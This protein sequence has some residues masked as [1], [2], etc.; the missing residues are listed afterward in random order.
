MSAISLKRISLGGLAV[1]L[2]VSFPA[3][4]ELTLGPPN[5]ENQVDTL[6]LHAIRGTDIQEPSGVDV[7]QS[8]RVLVDR[9]WFDF[10][11]DVEEGGVARV[12][13]AGA[14]GLPPESGILVSNQA[15][16]QI[17]TAPLDG[18]RNDTV[19]TVIPGSVFVIRSRTSLIGCIGFVGLPRYGKFRV[20]DVDPDARTVQFETLVNLNCGYR[21][22]EPGLPAR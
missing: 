19:V 21:D 16:D 14:L 10:A 5:F 20:L 7:A 18:Y 8:Q 1:L 9:S 13:T 4:G 17:H 12:Y 6:L 11:V 3:C 22:L 15:F 2:S